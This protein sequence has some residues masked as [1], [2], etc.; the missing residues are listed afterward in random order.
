MLL[1]STRLSLTSRLYLSLTGYLNE[2]T[3]CL[4]TIHQRRRPT[5]DPA[6]IPSPPVLSLLATAMTMQCLL[7]MVA[8]K[9][10]TTEPPHN[11]THLD[12]LASFVYQLLA[13]YDTTDTSGSLTRTFVYQ[14]LASAFFHGLMGDTCPPVP[15]HACPMAMA[16]LERCWRH[17]F[18]TANVPFCTALARYTRH[19]G[20]T[21][22]TGPMA[23]L[24]ARFMA[25]RVSDGTSKARDMQCDAFH[26]ALSVYVAMHTSFHGPAGARVEEAMRRVPPLLRKLAY[27]LDLH[28]PTAHRSIPIPTQ[29]STEFFSYR[30]VKAIYHQT[31]S[32]YTQRMYF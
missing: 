12:A 16:L 4:Q 26:D 19:G 15:W 5:M 2:F 8:L 1:G 9:S 21:D 27:T 28:D 30:N 18:A 3:Q 20:V 6:L 14:T 7:C 31:L 22:V 32:F 11:E 29:T 17:G 23:D 10:D 24:S 25:L 13:L